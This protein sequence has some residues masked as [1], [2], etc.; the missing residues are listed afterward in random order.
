MKTICHY[1]SD[2]G[3]GHASRSI[4]IIRE[5]VAS[6]EDIRV[7]AKTSGPFTFTQQ[8]LVHPR[9]IVIECKNDPEISLYENSHAVDR[10]RTKKKFLSWMRTWDDYI[11]RECAF[12]KENHVDLILSDI[13]P[14][15]FLI[16]E[17]LGIPGIAISNFS[18]DIIFRHLF[19]DLDETEQLANAYQ[20]ASFACILPF[21]IGMEV[22]P[23]REPVGLIS[24]RKTVSREKMRRNTGVS[25]TEILLYLDRSSINVLLSNK[26]QDTS[27]PSNS[28]GSVL[29]SYTDL[30]SKSFRGT[31]SFSGESGR[32]RFLLPSGYSFPNELS[33]PLTETESQNWLGMCDSIITKCGYSTVSEAVSAEIPLFVWKREGFIED[34]AIAGTI[35]RLGIGR[36]VSGP[37]EAIEYCCMDNSFHEK[38]KERFDTIDGIFKRNDTSEILTIIERMMA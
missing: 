18:W 35:E 11:F 1:I 24:R 26:M 37:G 31:G 25:D 17:I 28:L 12:C 9:I 33:I 2:Y 8:S 34:E 7:I 10:D 20:K 19:P 15:A 16:A 29:R 5:L 22:F 32:I 23:H 27:D 3:F 14:Q 38:Y 30:K 6:R 36:M 13:T 4:A 21:D